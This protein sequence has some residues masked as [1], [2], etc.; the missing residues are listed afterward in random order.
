MHMW[1]IVIYNYATTTFAINDFF[2]LHSKIVFI[3][4]HAYMCQ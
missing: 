4:D 3:H 1:L 2:I